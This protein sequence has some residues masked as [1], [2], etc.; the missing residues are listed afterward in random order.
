MRDVFIPRPYQPIAVNHIY[1]HK[2][3]GLFLPMG[4]GLLSIN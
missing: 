4:M 2:R 1:E 3:S